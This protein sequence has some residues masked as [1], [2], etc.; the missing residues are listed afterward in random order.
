[1]SAAEAAALELSFSPAM[2]D[3]VAVP[4]TMRMSIE[5]ALP[6]EHRG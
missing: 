3:G 1:M 2:R 4:F 5:F 6:D